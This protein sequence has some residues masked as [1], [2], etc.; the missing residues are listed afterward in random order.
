MN[1]ILSTENNQKNKKNKRK[2]QTLDMK[3]IIIIFSVLITVFAL[4]IVFA[5]VGAM[6]KANNNNKDNPIQVLNKPTIKIEKTD[7]VCTLTVSYDEGLDKI[8]YYWNNENDI[9][10]KNMNG[11]TTPFTTQILIPE[12]DYNV[13]YV[14][15][16]GIDGSINQIEQKFTVQNVQ[17]PNKPQISWFYNEEEKTID[18]VAESQKGIKNLTYQ[19]EN[20]EKVIVD[21]TEEN[22]K[23]LSVTIDAKRG[24]NKIV[25]TSTDLEEN[26]QIK[27]ALIQGIFNP[28]I[29]VQ[30]VENKTI[31]VNINHDMGFK[32]VVI[33]INGQEIIY[34]ETHPQYSSE[35][36]NI[37]TSQDVNR[38][39]LTVKI[40]V[41]TL[42]E[43]E[44]EYTYNASTEISD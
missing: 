14:K 16:T 5:K 33:N 20:E 10:E 34:D 27:D 32:K 30:L 39:K 29:K 38:G 13:L 21:S 35:I 11:S 7:D 6:I 12:G 3:K 18:I 17:D 26:T 2:I 37:N 42:E 9:I 1:Q 8:S 25:I 24:T 23:T 43:P 44:K 4:V 36:T 19:W 15:A 28:E 41:Y 31:I 40:S 22:Q